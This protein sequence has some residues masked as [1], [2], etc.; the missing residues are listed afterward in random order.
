MQ[1]ICWSHI[2][3]LISTK[4]QPCLL[5]ISIT[6]WSWTVVNLNRTACFSCNDLSEL[7]TELTTSLLCFCL[8]SDSLSSLF[9]LMHIK[10]PWPFWKIYH[11]LKYT[12]IEH[13]VV[14]LYKAKHNIAT[15]KHYY[16]NLKFAHFNNLIFS[17]CFLTVGLFSL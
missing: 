10:N 2:S 7:C 16:P 17:L 5:E 12:L 4:Q 6:S 15:C 13:T 8:S 14:S 3:T 11:C 1:N 9:W